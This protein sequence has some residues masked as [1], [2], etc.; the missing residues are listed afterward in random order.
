MVSVV[1]RR[2]DSLFI[3]RTHNSTFCIPREPDWPAHISAKRFN[4]PAHVWDGPRS[5]QSLINLLQKKGN[6]LSWELIKHSL[7]YTHDVPLTI[8]GSY[9]LFSSSYDSFVPGRRYG[10]HDLLTFNSDMNNN[11]SPFSVV[12]QLFIAFFCIDENIIFLSYNIYVAE[13]AS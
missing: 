4:Q 13:R 10:S 6:L 12:H 11:S 5:K 7:D 8:K 9:L 1:H 2:Q 3:S